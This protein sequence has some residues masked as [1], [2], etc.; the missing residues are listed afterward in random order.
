MSKNVQ[1]IDPKGKSKIIT[2]TLSDLVGNKKRELGQE[3]GVWKFDG[4]VLKNNKTFESYGIDTNDVI[5]TS[6]YTEG[7]ML[8]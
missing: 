7:G 4:E 6:I 2:I 3:K 1:L 5:T 8:N